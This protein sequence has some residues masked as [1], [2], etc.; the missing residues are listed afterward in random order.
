MMMDKPETVG[1]DVSDLAFDLL[2]AGDLK[3]STSDGSSNGGD[4]V[5]TS[6]DKEV[7]VGGRPIKQSLL[8]NI[9]NELSLLA[10][11][12][13]GVSD[14]VKVSVRD[15]QRLKDTNC[16]TVDSPRTRC[17]GQVGDSPSRET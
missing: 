2:N 5:Q 4:K 15:G 13:N 10:V 17:T 6:S 9:Y 14:K 7:D 3:S 16:S 1:A 12:G 11:E 8:R